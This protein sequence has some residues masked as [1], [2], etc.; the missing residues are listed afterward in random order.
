ME[1]T[2]LEGNRTVKRHMYFTAHVCSSH[3]LTCTIIHHLLPHS[4]CWVSPPQL[5]RPMK[6]QQQLIR[7]A[8]CESEGQVALCTVGAPPP[9]VL[10]GGVR[11]TGHFLGLV[12][13]RL[14]LGPGKLGPGAEIL[15][16]RCGHVN[17]GRA[18]PSR[19]YL[20]RLRHVVI[21]TLRSRKQ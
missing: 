2:P 14:S 3:L 15:E 1:K 18:A 8:P 6:K 17:T 5:H 20:R 11:C 13:T 16:D 19:R 9:P 21:E 12:G 4:E 10:G 7:L